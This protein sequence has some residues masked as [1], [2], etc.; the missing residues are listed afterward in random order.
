MDRVKLL[1]RHMM[2][3]LKKETTEGKYSE[4]G[5][6]V[7]GEEKLIEFKGVYMP[8][9]SQDFKNYPQ[10]FIEHSDLDLKTMEK[11]ENGDIVVI[12]GEEWKVMASL[13]ESYLA[14]IKM[15]LLRKDK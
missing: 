11:L 14:D 7:E 15:Y 9:S 1:K 5:V 8:F 13:F 4:A 2:S 10:G 3:L 12:N 6:W